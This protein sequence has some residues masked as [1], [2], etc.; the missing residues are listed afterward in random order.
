MS[1]N[2]VLNVD[3]ARK[4]GDQVMAKILIVEDEA[5][6]REIAMVILRNVGHTVEEVTNGEEALQR[7]ADEPFDVVLMDVQMP[8]MDGLQATRAI[9]ADP[10]LAHI[11]IVGVTARASA[12][13]R[14]EMLAAGMDAVVTK[15][16]H[17]AH[18]R[19]V[20]DEVLR[21]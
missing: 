8:V 16:Y 18:L 2:N 14:D 6:N 10:S 3:G 4:G 9:R 11:R 17:N 7:L 5:S 21:T 13:D 1:L 15:P 20:V 19:T 12:S